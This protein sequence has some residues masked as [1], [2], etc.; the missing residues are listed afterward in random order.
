MVLGLPVVPALLV[1]VL[2]R[3]VGDAVSALALS[4]FFGRL[5]MGFGEGTLGL[6]RRAP[7]GPGQLFLDWLATLV[8]LGHGGSLLHRLAYP[9][10]FG[11]T[12]ALG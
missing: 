11:Q 3:S 6:G 5:V 8:R 2:E 1:G 9:S 10:G 4:V 7:D 12:S